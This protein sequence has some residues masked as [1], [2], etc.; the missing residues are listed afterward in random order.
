LNAG[1]GG[2][3]TINRIAEMFGRPVVHLDPRPGDVP[4]SQADISRTMELLDWKPKI[5]FHDG[6]AEWLRS[7]G[8][9]PKV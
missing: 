6:L 7:Q 5:E 8:I 4:R 2:S 9:E 3:T 1:A